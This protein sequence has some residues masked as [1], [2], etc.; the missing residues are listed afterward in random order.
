M[1]LSVSMKSKRHSALLPLSHL[2]YP[3]KFFQ[4]VT[5]RKLKQHLLLSFLLAQAFLE[6]RALSSGNLTAYSRIFKRVQ[7]QVIV[8]ICP[9]FKSKL[10][11]LNSLFFCAYTQVCKGVFHIPF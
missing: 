2:V 3:R 11:I 8:S 9:F 5:T 4:R 6:I 7:D 10:L 1:I